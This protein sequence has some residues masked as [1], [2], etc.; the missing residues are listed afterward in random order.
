MTQISLDPLDLAALLCSRVCHD[1]I[2]PVGAIANGLE[3]LEDEKDPE[4]RAMAL[5]LVKKSSA[6][7]SAQ[8]QFCRLAFGAAGSAGAD[9]DSGDAQN[10]ANGLLVDDRTKIEWNVARAYM[11]KNKVKLLLNM[12]LIASKAIPRG[13]LLTVTVTGTGNET[14]ARIE[15]AGPNLRLAH[16]VAQMLSGAPEGPVDAH[17]IQ[18]YYA[19]LV[20]K[21]AGMQVSARTENDKV[22]LEALPLAE[23]LALAS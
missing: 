2:S 22:V 19:A 20:A 21:A 23:D 6:K 5:D 17:S 12:C 11:P 10:V 1:V 4:M 16:G 15:A 7:A 9:I 8:L 3:M 13:G 14:S 18:P